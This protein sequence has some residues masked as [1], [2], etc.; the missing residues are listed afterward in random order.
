MMRLNVSMPPVMHRALKVALGRRAAIAAAAG[1]F[2][3]E[4]VSGWMREAA[5]EVIKSFR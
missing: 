1:Q 5:Q 2:K 3:A 4:T